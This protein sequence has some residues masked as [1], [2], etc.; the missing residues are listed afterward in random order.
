VDA[1][2]R[3]KQEPGGRIALNGSGTLLAT[4]LRAGLVDEL[5]LLSHPIVVG[6]GK[7]LF[8]DG[9]EPIGLELVTQ[10]TLDAGV[11]SLTYAPADPA[12]D[13]GLPA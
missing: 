13:A 3:L 9:G 2:R 4:L 1:V 6:A 12:A 11:L 8:E 7:H 5:N 10:T